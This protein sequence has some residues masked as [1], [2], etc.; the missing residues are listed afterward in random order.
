MVKVC[1]PSLVYKTLLVLGGPCAVLIPL[2]RSGI[3]S[4][5]SPFLLLMTPA[6]LCLF[7]FIAFWQLAVD[8][9][10]E[11]FPWQERLIGTLL[12]VLITAFFAAAASHLLRKSKGAFR[13]A[14]WSGLIIGWMLIGAISGFQMEALSNKAQSQN[15]QSI[16]VQ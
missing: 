3:I 8:P 5:R 9:G 12:I 15:D 6:T 14:L 16:L 10:G 1:R 11:Q 7:P 13:T 4:S 2:V